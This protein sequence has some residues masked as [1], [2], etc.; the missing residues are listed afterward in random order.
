M[1]S[2][3]PSRHSSAQRND[4]PWANRSRH[5]HRAQLPEPAKSEFHS[6]ENCE[7]GVITQLAINLGPSNGKTVR[8]AKRV[9][10][11]QGS[12]PRL[13]QASCGSG[14]QVYRFFMTLDGGAVALGDPPAFGAGGAW[15]PL[16]SPPV[17]IA[18]AVFH[19][20][21]RRGQPNGEYQS[22]LARRWSALSPTSKAVAGVAAAVVYP[23]GIAVLG[24][25]G[26]LA[27]KKRVV[28]K[29]G[30]VRQVAYSQTWRRDDPIVQLPPG[31][32]HEQSYSMT[33]GISETQTREL[34]QSLGLKLGK[35]GGLTRDLSSKFGIATTISEQRSVTDTVTLRND[36][37]RGY[38]LYARWFV[39]H[40]I[41]V[42]RLEMPE[43]RDWPTTAP[44]WQEVNGA[45]EPYQRSILCR[46]SFTS[47]DNVVL[48]YCE[49]DK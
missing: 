45:P 44:E 40:E 16:E 21:L 22:T 10:R 18:S 34:A 29:A 5:G 32:T 3:K 41:I 24:R 42:Q 30:E 48:T 37:T 39:R 33:F 49:V 20:A 13:K 27:V 12:R 23:V 36:G 26:Y 9:G 47:P 14:Q 11:G 28:G 4:R 25:L 19:T 1:H 15:P 6:A 46:V 7:G 43:G 8:R 31:A 2:T 38:R 17:V 35:A